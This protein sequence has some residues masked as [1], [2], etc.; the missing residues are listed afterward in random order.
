MWAAT[1]AATV[2]E[3]PRSREPPLLQNC[4]AAVPRTEF[5]ITPRCA[6]PLCR[7]VPLPRL[8]HLQREHVLPDLRRGTLR[9]SNG[10]S[11]VW[12]AEDA[13]ARDSR[14]WHVVNK[15]LFGGHLLLQAVHQ[16]PESVWTYLHEDL[17]GR[18]KRVAMAAKKSMRLATV[19]MSVMVKHRNVSH[20]V[21][22][23]PP[24]DQR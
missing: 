6:S 19:Y 3:H 4:R 18:M 5:G 7:P 21:L 12:L 11:L 17:I 2:C 15:N 13:I 10:G 1:G 23:R 16:N 8:R 20:L 24:L 9:L 22:E 14:C